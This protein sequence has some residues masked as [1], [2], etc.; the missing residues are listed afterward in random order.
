MQKRDG[1]RAAQLS[2]R[3]DPA[4]VILIIKGRAAVKSSCEVPAPSPYDRTCE[5][6]RRA[7]A[8]SISA[9]RGGVG[10]TTLAREFAEDL[11][12]NAPVGLEKLIWL[13]AKK[14]FYTAILG[15]WEWPT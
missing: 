2:V 1:S 12:K 7:F 11:V 3:K 4:I 9:C 5:V 6:L 8:P 13:S 10:K 14:Q 15:R